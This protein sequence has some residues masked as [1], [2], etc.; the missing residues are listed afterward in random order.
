MQLNPGDKLLWREP[1]E[2]EG[3]YRPLYREWRRNHGEEVEFVCYAKKG[4]PHVLLS[5]DTDNLPILNV[6][7]RAGV[8]TFSAGYFL[9]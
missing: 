9:C 7:T 1:E 3:W 8:V 4:D 6:R 5:L 2:G